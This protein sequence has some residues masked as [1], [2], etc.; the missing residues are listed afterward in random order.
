[1]IREARPLAITIGLTHPAWSRLGI[2]PWHPAIPSQRRADYG[3]TTREQRYGKIT[4]PEGRI[5]RIWQCLVRL[6][7][8]SSSLPFI[9]LAY[10]ACTFPDVPIRFTF[11]MFKSIRRSNAITTFYRCKMFNCMPLVLEHHST[12]SLVFAIL[13]NV[14]CT[15]LYRLVAIITAIGFRGRACKCEL[16][17]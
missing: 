16:Q 17:Y 9:V 15:T 4:A 3:P 7:L 11:R 6:P 14:S 5:L 8:T 10:G 12:A 13:I 2:A 1:M